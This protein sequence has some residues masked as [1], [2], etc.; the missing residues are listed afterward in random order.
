MRI[1]PASST[2]T[3][4]RRAT[5]KH[6]VKHNVKAERRSTDRRANSNHSSHE[7]AR[8]TDNSSASTHSG[9]W[10]NAEFATQIIGQSDP[11]PLGQSDVLNASCAYDK[12]INPYLR[13]LHSKSA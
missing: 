11:A 3:Q 4:Y 5:D 13:P 12:V 8:H 9:K 7:R 10:L 6:V 2:Y 1:L